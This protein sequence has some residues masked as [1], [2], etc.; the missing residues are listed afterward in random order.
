MDRK[1]GEEILTKMWELM[2]QVIREC[3]GENLENLDS[4]V[5]LALKQATAENVPEK[6]S[7]M[8]SEKTLEAYKKLK[9]ERRLK[10]ASPTKP[11]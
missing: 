6:V 7:I 9:E 2:E 4:V 11:Q 10:K 3:A 5:H 8:L 1:H